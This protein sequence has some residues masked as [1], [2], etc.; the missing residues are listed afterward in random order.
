M[1]SNANALQ[2][3]LPVGPA[4]SQ[5]RSRHFQTPLR[6]PRLQPADEPRADD[7]KPAEPRVPLPA[8]GWVPGTCPFPGGA[9]PIAFG[10]VDGA[11]MCHWHYDTFD[12]PKLPAPA[13]PP[14]PPAPPPPTGSVLI[15]STR[16]CKNQAFRF[17]DRLFGF[18][19]HLEATPEIISAMVAAGKADIEK[20]LG[21]GGE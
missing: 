20:A 7:P 2:H 1:T 6:A 5:R 19:Y 15:S 13:N 14:P 17:K 16:T 10:L 18:Q 4:P 9:E 12:L 11:E 21:P 3:I 8:V